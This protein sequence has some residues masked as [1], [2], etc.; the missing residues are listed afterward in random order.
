MNSEGIRRFRKYSLYSFLG[1]LCLTALFAIY[2]VLIG[3]FGQFELNVLFTTTVIALCSVAAMSCAA[4]AQKLTHPVFPLVGIALSV[5][6]GILMIVDI[7][8]WF[9]NELYWK[10]SW[11]LATL[12]IGSALFSVLALPTLWEKHRWVQRA[13]GVVIALLSGLILLVIFGGESTELVEQIVNKSIAVLSVLLALITLAVPILYRIGVAESG[14]GGETL[15]L[16]RRE[17]GTYADKEGKVYE[18]K[19]VISAG[20]GK[21]VVNGTAITPK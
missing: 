1:F 20:T 8:A 6:T 5:L 12:A 11:S 13:A 4:Y 10:I 21:Q 14:R 19:E 18:V 7:W 9:R 2:V 15:V 16:T 3:E 17:D